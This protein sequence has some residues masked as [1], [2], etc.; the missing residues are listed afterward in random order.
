MS[1]ARDKE[2]LLLGIDVGGTTTAAGLVTLDG[3]VLVSRTQPT[4]GPRGVGAVERLL[5]LTADIARL[6]A[7]RERGLTGV[8]A[9]LPGL[10]DVAAGTVGGEAHHVPELSGVPVARLL[11]ETAGAPAVVDNDVN[12]LALGESRWGAGR[13]SRSLVL[14]AIGTGVGGGIVLDGRLYRGAGGFGGELG[15]VPIELH[16]RPCVCGARGCLKAHVAGPDLGIEA[17][18]RLGRPVDAVALFALAAAGDAVAEAVLVDATEALAAGLTIIVN[19][20]NPETLLVAGSV[21]RAFAARDADLR[22]RLARR[23]YAAALASTRLAFLDL[24][25]DGSV[26]GGAALVLHERERLHSGP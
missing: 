14:L 18:R 10:V 17:T 9:G 19:G 16:G 25:K 24:G 12:A 2:A 11:A 3:R 7:A 20:L 26:R 6:P 8:G 5:A 23:A 22:A 21:G 4:H 15:H 1:A 13:G